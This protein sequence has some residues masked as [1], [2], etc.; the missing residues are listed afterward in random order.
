MTNLT[1]NH[2]NGE[3][4]LV[5]GGNGKTG[6]RVAE[7]LTAAGHVVR[8]ASRST[9]PAFDWDDPT[10]WAAALD[11]VTAAYVTF[12][13]DLAVP[14]ATDVIGAFGAAARAH[15]LGR[16]VLLSGRG[17]PEAQACEEVLLGCGVDTTVV[18]CS[19][20]AQNF[21]EHFLI[22]AV[23][24]GVI[25]MPAGDVREP[26]VDADDIADVA[27]V[28][29][30]R[31]GYAGRV[32]EVTGPRLLSFADLAAELTAATGRPIA[33]VDVTP[34]DYAAGAIAAG[35]PAEE[36]EMLAE[37]FT[38]I[39]DGHNATLTDGVREVLGR[40]ARDFAD[41]ARATA[42]AGAWDVEAPAPQ[43]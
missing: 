39:F 15:G 37:L 5:I 33:Y 6:R 12:Q 23:L 28:A 36:A 34:A 19:F 14:G 31:P 7:R 43:R 27:V 17:E 24:E 4:I 8:K 2:R 38:R 40:P 29:L 42:A 20:F 26:I 18:R 41:F 32:V 9:S 13:P 35:V 10:T 25:A 3:C 22:D 30:T 11:G 1:P 16:L 21:S